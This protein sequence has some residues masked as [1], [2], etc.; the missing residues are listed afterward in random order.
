MGGLTLEQDGVSFW[1][2]AITPKQIGALQQEM[3]RHQKRPSRGG[4]RAANHLLPTAHAVSHSST[5]LDRLAPYFSAPPRLVRSILFDKSA[6]RNWLVT[7]HQ[8]R[9]VAVSDRFAAEG[10]RNWSMKAGVLHAEPPQSVLETMV[11]VRIHLD[12]TDERRG[13]LSVLPRSHRYGVLG[14]AEI[15]R[16]VVEDNTVACTAKAGD[17][18]LMRPLVLH[19]SNKM[20]EGQHRRILHLEFSDYILPKGIVWAG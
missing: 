19:A 20:S 13:C 7:W 15:E 10:W 9:T 11:T 12:D 18:L 8:D 1:R 17:A 5:L 6:S 2:D 4:L 14:R 3:A 16:K